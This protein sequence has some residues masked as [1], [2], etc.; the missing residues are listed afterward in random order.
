MRRAALFG[1]VTLALG[2]LGGEA[3]AA[4]ASPPAGCSGTNPVACTGTFPDGA[5]FLVEVPGNWSGTLLLYSH[6]YVAPGSANPARDVGDPGTRALALAS[7]YALAGSSYARTGWALQ[8]A[9]SDQI[10]VLDWFDGSFGHPRRTIAWGHSLG[11]IITAGLLQRNPERFSAGLPMCGV[12]AGGVGTWNQ[13][14]DGEFA[15]KTLLSGTAALQLV[16][17][18]NPAANLALAES[19]G[20]AAQSTP[21]GRARLALA[22]ALG[23]T[24]GWF[25]PASPEPAA[26]DFASREANQYLWLSRVD[27][28]FI[29]A[30][31]A[32]LEARA[33]G[34]P[35]WN[36]EVDY[37]VQL[38]H[39]ID[40]AEVAALYQAAGLDLDADLAR[41]DAA[42]R[43]SADP[44][45]VA[46]LVK[47]IVFDGQIST[48]VLTMH[49]TGDGLVV[50][51][52]E[53]A[54]AAA[55]RAAGNE[56]LL[57]QVYVH[58]A[59]HCSFTPGETVAALQ[60]LVHRLD[61]G[62]WEGSTEP[63]VMNAAASSF[64]ATFNPAP[65]SFL[66]TRPAPFLRPFNLRPG[67]R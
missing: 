25:D 36:T 64:G 8:E 16:D 42:P 51:N 4:A 18:T 24:P 9:F 26:T 5:Q 46:Y 23:D 62:R 15:F 67:E 59:G 49:T 41:L 63:E 22:A 34:N 19:L 20:A 33:G 47:Y 30:L 50:D 28:P 38:A 40:A 65:P 39:S 60:T 54:Y 37:R 56:R 58:R 61:S 7:G 43:I 57:R 3:P 29:F 66:E 10:A 17:I 48:P 21:Q 27:D 44:Q 11:G 14:L 55:V 52:D 35:S 12:L 1:L 53:S 32:E 2:F 6:G 13:A 31:R 45:A